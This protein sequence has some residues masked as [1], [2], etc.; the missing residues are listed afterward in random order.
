MSSGF[1]GG[2]AYR[3]SDNLINLVLSGGINVQYVYET[4]YSQ[5]LC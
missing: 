5:N 4:K 1:A 3:K 2:M